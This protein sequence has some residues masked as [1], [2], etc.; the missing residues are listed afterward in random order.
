[1]KI[2]YRA[3][4]SSAHR[5]QLPYESKCLR[6]HG[7][8]YQVEVEIEGQ[9]N[10]TGMVVDF[11]HL[12]KAIQKYDHILLND[13]IDQ[14]TVENLVLNLLSEIL[15]LPENDNFQFVKIRIWEDKDSY[16]E[17]KWSRMTNEI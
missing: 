4:I 7:H 2:Y 12:K 13:V 1:M 3:E 5:L 10:K 9:L 17:E 15:N 14:P 11:T 6:T 16:A 8:N